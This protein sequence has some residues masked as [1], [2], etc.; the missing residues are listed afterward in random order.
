VTSEVPHVSIVVVSWNAREHLRR[1]ISSIARHTRDV[2]LEFVVVDNASSDGTVAALQRDYPDLK[3][4]AN[5]RNL[6]FARAGN[7]G[8]SAAAG[9][10]LLLLNPDTYVEDDVIGRAVRFMA[11][12]PEIG[13]L[14]CRLRY[15]DGRLQHNANRALS[16]RRSLLE[17]LWLYKLIPRSRRARFLLDGYW[18]HDEEADVDWLAGAFMLLRRELFAASGGFDER[19][20]M[21]GEDSEWC[22]RLRRMGHRVVFTPAPGT[23][24][25]TGS[26]SSDL[27]WAE[28]ERLRRCY[29]GGIDSYAALNG[30][31][32]AACYR[33]AELLGSVVRFSVYATANL[34]RRDDY[35]SRQATFFRWL[36]EFYVA[37]AGDKR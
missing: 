27:L 34:L 35:Y 16:V 11:T 22:M 21:Y 31:G 6:G 5:A 26:V 20:F 1:C 18:D 14:G 28:K 33:V 36:I 32:L 3:I 8:M 4:V 17:R 10:L 19:F 30:R 37:P 24:F 7:Q 13:M 2:T 25:H 9:E 23:V 12:R 15:P 29:V